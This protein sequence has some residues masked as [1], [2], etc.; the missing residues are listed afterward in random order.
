[1]TAATTPS[2][3]TGSAADQWFAQYN[4][5]HRLES[6]RWPADPADV[7]EAA[8]KL[9]AKPPTFENKQISAPGG[10]TLTV[11]PEG[12]TPLVPPSTG[13]S[14]CERFE[15][16]LQSGDQIDAEGKGEPP[17]LVEGLLTVGTANTMFGAPGSAKTFA[18]SHLSFCIAEGVSFFGFNV[19]QGDVLYIAAEASRVVRDRMRAYRKEHEEHTLGRVHLLPRSVNLLDPAGDVDGLLMLIERHAKRI[20]RPIVLVVID[21]LARSMAGGNENSTEDMS[22]AVQASERINELT[23][24]AVLYVHHCGKDAGKGARG[25]NALLGGVD[26]E[27]ELTKDATNRTY[28]IRVSKQ[29]DGVNE[30][31]TFGFRLKGVHLRTNEWGKSVGSAVVVPLTAP[32]A[33]IQR[34]KPISG[35]N[36]MR[37]MEAVR[38]AVA[39][40]GGKEDGRAL[41][42]VTRDEVKSEFNIK[43]GH[44]SKNAFP[45]ALTG[46]LAGRNLRQT[47]DWINIP[48]PLQMTFTPP[49]EE[50]YE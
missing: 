47:G 46:L 38:D 32:A 12:G 48:A 39:K 27:F 22:I 3:P 19:R 7:A 37:V 49:P 9:A 17:E 14:A 25:S 2:P 26:G 13:Q 24:A 35:P 28:Q 50:P 21:T 5:A 41:G 40:H 44:A 31:V 8:A 10:K 16:V 18:A 1:M 30:G 4:A 45:Q 29:R 34:A 33:H 11:P 36:Q 6:L 43:N 42:H 15:S 20:G 23:G